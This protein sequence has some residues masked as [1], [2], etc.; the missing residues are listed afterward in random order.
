MI[1]QRVKMKSTFI[2]F[3]FLLAIILSGA[4]FAIAPAK[5]PTTYSY[6][7]E[8]GTTYYGPCVI[9]DAINDEN[10]ADSYNVQLAAGEYYEPVIVNKSIT[11]KGTGATA[12]DTVIIAGG[13]GGTVTIDPGVC[14]VLENLSILNMEDGSPVVNNGQ[15]TLNNCFLNGVY[16]S[17]EVRGE[18]VSGTHTETTTSTDTST[19]N[20]VATPTNPAAKS[21]SV[22]A[23]T[24]GPIAAKVTAPIAAL[25]PSTGGSTVVDQQKILVN[26]A[27]LQKTVQKLVSQVLKVQ[28]QICNL[29]VQ[30]FKVQPQLA[31]TVIWGFH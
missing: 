6:V 28:I 25:S 12:E 26:Q 20:F 9:Q 11:I 23:K 18:A 7:V 17:H 30:V 15:L 29:L 13:E 1:I 16:V 31:Q 21:G 8:T 3:A 27:T 4:S 24:T 19:S 5:E 2:V 10:T 22:A 14:V